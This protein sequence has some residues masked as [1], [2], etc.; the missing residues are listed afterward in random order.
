MATNHPPAE[1][2]NTVLINNPKDNR[3]YQYWMFCV[4]RVPLPGCAVG[5]THHKNLQMIACRKYY[6]GYDGNN[7]DVVHNDYLDFINDVL[8]G[9]IVDK[10]NRNKDL[11]GLPDAFKSEIVKYIPYFRPYINIPDNLKDC[12]VTPGFKFLLYAQY[13]MG[14][15]FPT[16]LIHYDSPEKGFKLNFAAIAGEVLNDHNINSGVKYDLGKLV[17]RNSELEHKDGAILSDFPACNGK[18][19]QSCIEYILNNC[20]NM[21]IETIQLIHHETIQRILACFGVRI[22]NVE[23]DGEDLDEYESITNWITH[24]DEAISDPGIR[25]RILASESGVLRCLNAM[26]NYINSNPMVLNE[27]LRHGKHKWTEEKKRKILSKY[28]FNNRPYTLVNPYSIADG[29]KMFHP[30]Q[31]MHGIPTSIDDVYETRNK[32]KEYMQYNQNYIASIKNH[33]LYNTQLPF[34][35]DPQ[36]T[37]ERRPLVGTNIIPFVQLGGQTGGYKGITIMKILFY[38]L[39]QQA[40]LKGEPIAQDE[41]HEINKSLAIMEKQDRVLR[42]FYSD[43]HC[44]DEL[45]DVFKDANDSTINNIILHAQKMYIEYLKKYAERETVMLQIADQICDRLM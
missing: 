22:I 30:M 1:I 8:V 2:I 12:N 11:S 7:G 27:E 21:T 41:L 31:V 32:I 26:I 5:I 36:I 33:A 39:E 4:Q 16:V 35:S 25:I 13:H 23:R 37:I 29:V 20:V 6:K 18:G 45:N 24:I 44:L 14:Y 19:G 42:K 3:A 40:D 28:F 17:Y 10:V 34:S 15:Q 43:T 9:W 38:N